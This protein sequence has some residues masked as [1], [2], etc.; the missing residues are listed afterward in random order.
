MCMRMR[1][2]MLCYCLGVCLVADAVAMAAVIQV[3]D[4]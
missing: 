1:M 3:E 4:S 2:R